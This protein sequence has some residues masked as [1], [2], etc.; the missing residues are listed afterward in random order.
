MS[1]TPA[2]TLQH[3][4]SDPEVRTAEA[5]RLLSHPARIQLLLALSERGTCAC[6]DLVEA[7]PLAQPTVSQHLKALREAGLIAPQALGNRVC[8]TLSPP[9]RDALLAQ[10]QP[11]LSKLQAWQP[12][13][14]NCT[15]LSDT[16]C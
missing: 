4:F 16:C 14:V 15:P 9:G 11:L 1:R 8:Y 2:S 5:C 3:Q 6:A 12:D 7:S 10:L 13:D